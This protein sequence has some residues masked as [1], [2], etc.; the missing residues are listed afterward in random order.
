MKNSERKRPA[1][2]T[3]QNPLW[4]GEKALKPGVIRDKSRNEKTT[5]PFVDSVAHKKNTRT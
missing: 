2:S 3:G 1:D 4:P 5:I